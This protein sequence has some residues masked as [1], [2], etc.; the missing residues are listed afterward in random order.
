MS[1]SGR[2]STQPWP[3]VPVHGRLASVHLRDLRQPAAETCVRTQQHVAMDADSVA[4]AQRGMILFM[5]LQRALVTVG[6]LMAQG[7]EDAA[8]PLSD[9]W[10]ALL[11]AR[12]LALD[13]VLASSAVAAADGLD[14]VAQA[15][16]RTRARPS[17]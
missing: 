2:P 4:E 12:A 6:T 15:L 11:D 5:T 9:V 14:A 10:N 8:G 16:S 1:H 7:G 17:D 13:R 3:A